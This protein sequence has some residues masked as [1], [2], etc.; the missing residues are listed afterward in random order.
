MAMLHSRR[1]HATRISAR[2]DRRRR[3][4][5]AAPPSSVA[6]CRAITSTRRPRGGCARCRRRS[7]WSCKR[8]RGACS[9]PTETTRRAPTRVDVAGAVDVYVAKLPPAVQRDVRALLQL[10]EHGSSLFRG[11]ATRFTHLSPAEQDATLRRLA[12]LVADGA[13]ARLSGA[14]HARLRRLLARRSHLAAHRL[15]GADAAQAPVMTIEPRPRHPQ[16]RH[17]RLRLVVVGTGAGGA[18]VAREAARAGLRVIALEEGAYSEPRDFTQREDEMLPLLVPGRRRPHHRRR[19]HHR[20]AGARRRRLDG[21]QHEPVQARAGVGARRLAPR[22]LARGRARRRTTR[23]SSAICRSRR[24]TRAA[25]IATTR[26]CGA[27]S[28]SWAG[29]AASCRTIGAAASAP[30]S[31]SSA[32]PSTPSRTR[33]RCSS[34]PP[35]TPA[36][37]SSPSAASSACVVQARARRRRAG[38]R[39]RRARPRRRD[40]D[41]ARAR[42]LPRGQRRRLGGAGAAERAARSVGTRRPRAA[43]ASRRRRRRRLRRDHRGLERHSAELGVHREARRSTSAGQRRS[44]LD[45]HRVRASDRPRLVAARLRRRRT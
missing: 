9:P 21:A 31:A 24:S 44:H 42:G 39:A 34:P 36:R 41:G 1:A 40:G 6:R 11:G 33:S 8:W 20:L 7:I 22:R 14:A 18:M 15:L 13:A 4:C 19:R 28:R 30:A 38:A 2:R 32:A 29:A 12:A 10:V 3:C 23:S 37:A 5:S 25:S 35:S 17:A 16:R 45:H 43:P 26:S 27:A